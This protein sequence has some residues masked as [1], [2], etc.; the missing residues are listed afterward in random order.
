M[1]QKKHLFL[2]Q[3]KTYFKICVSKKQVS[4]CNFNLRNFRVN[5]S[6]AKGKGGVQ[7]PEVNHP[8]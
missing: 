4:L 1:Q 8:K 6:A 7:V 2:V 3:N 5:G